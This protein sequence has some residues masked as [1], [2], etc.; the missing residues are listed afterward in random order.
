MFIL[1]FLSRSFDIFFCLFDV[2]IGSL[3]RPY[4]AHLTYFLSIRRFYWLFATALSRSFDIF[5]CLF[6]VFIGSLRRPYHVHTKFLSQKLE[7]DNTSR[8]SIT[9]LYKG[10]WRHSSDV[11]VWCHNSR[12][13]IISSFMIPCLLLI[14]PFHN[15]FLWITHFNWFYLLIF[16]L[17]TE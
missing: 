12:F 6:D 8:F 3:R 16:F 17:V 13:S 9:E 5:F 11:Y 4:H 14:F 10:S 2:F 1:I 15:Y 7:F